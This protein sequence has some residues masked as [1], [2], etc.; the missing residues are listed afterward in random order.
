MTISTPLSYIPYKYSRRERI[1]H[2]PRLIR[3]TLQLPI[4]PSK[5]RLGRKR[6]TKRQPRKHNLQYHRHR[7]PWAIA[8][9][10]EIR[11]HHVTQM[12]AD[13]HD[14]AARR[15]LL[16]RLV[17][18]ADC[19]RVYEGVCGETAAGVEEGCCV[20]CGGVERGDGDDEADDGDAVVGH[21]VEAAFLFAIRVP[22]Y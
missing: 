11:T 20:A 7:V 8:I 1:I 14:S 19:P 15:P 22:C 9:R 6:H 12:A 2:T 18:R 17:Q 3:R 16:G 4:L 5:I 13:I 21:D 10:E